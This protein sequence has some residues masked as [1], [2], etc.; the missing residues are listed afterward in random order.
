[1]L[2]NFGKDTEKVL[3]EDCNSVKIRICCNKKFSSNRFSNFLKFKIEKH[4]YEFQSNV[5]NKDLTPHIVFLGH[6]G[7]S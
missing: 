4:C 7:K 3:H 2:L 5:R 1:M 6:F